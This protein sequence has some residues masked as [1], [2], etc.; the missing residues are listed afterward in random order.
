MDPDPWTWKVA[1]VQRF[2]QND[3]PRYVRDRGSHLPDIPK[4]VQALGD[5]E[6]DGASL[7]DAVDGATLRDQLGLRAIRDQGAI[8]YCIRKLRNTS[9]LYRGQETSEASGTTAA[10]PAPPLLPGITALPFAAAELGAELEQRE[11]IGEHVRDHETEVR[12]ERGRKRRKLDLTTTASLPT[13]VDSDPAAYLPDTALRLDGLFFGGTRLGHDITFKTHDLLA[14]SFDDNGRMS[15]FQLV[16]PATAH[17]GEVG[18]V[19]ARMFHFLQIGSEQHIKLHRRGKPVLAVLPYPA[20]LRERKVQS[21]L[22]VQAGS[23]VACT[24]TRENVNMLETDYVYEGGEQES[25]GEWDFLVQKYKQGSDDTEL[26]VLGQSEAA[27]EVTESDGSI[28]EDREAGEDEDERQIEKL[29]IREIVEDYISTYTKEWSE[30]KLPQWE[31]KRAWKVWRAFKQSGTLRDEKINYA[32]G[33]IEELTVRLDKKPD[34]LKNTIIS[35]EWTTRAAVERDCARLDVTLEDLIEQRWMIEV[36]QRKKE[37]NHVIHHR[38]SSNVD[39]LQMTAKS[40]S[41]NTT[42]ELE[43]SD[44]ISISPTRATHVDALAGELDR[45]TPMGDDDADEADDEFHTPEASLLTEQSQFPQ[46]DFDASDGF[47]AAS[48]EGAADV[49]DKE[50]GNTT[51]SLNPSLDSS[52]RRS[53]DRPVPEHVEAVQGDQASEDDLPSPSLLPSMKVKPE[54]AIP[55]KSRIGD[56]GGFSNHPIEVSSDSAHSP[57]PPRR[58]K[59]NSKSSYS[60]V[61]EDATADTAD[62]REYDGFKS[63]FDR[64]GMLMKVL[65]DSGSQVR[66]DLHARLMSDSRQI[67]HTELVAM[68][69]ACCEDNTNIDSSDLMMECANL[70]AIW[71]KCDHAYRFGRVKDRE[72]WREILQD[73]AQVPQF[74]HM[75]NTALIKMKSSMF[76]AQ[77]HTR[78]T[79]APTSDVVDLLSNSDG[80]KKVA[81]RHK[82][83]KKVEESQSAKKSRTTAHARQQR[84]NELIETQ[85][86]ESSQLADLAPPTSAKS[87]ITINP[88]AVE[89]GEQPIYVCPKIAKKM[90][91]HQINGVRFLWREITAEGDAD[92]PQGCLLAHTMG[93]GKTMQAIA[94]L[95]AVVEASES[96]TKSIRKQ[97]PRTLRLKIERGKRHLRILILCPPTLLQNWRKEIGM[98]ARHKIGH[99]YVIDATDKAVNVERIEEWYLSGGTLLIGFE[100][101]R[102]FVIRNTEK[103]Q[104]Q[105]GERLDELLVAGP[106]L[107]VAD[108]AHNLKNPKAN[109]SQAVSSFKTR[110]RV[111]LTGT[112]MSNDVDEIY[113]LISW[114]APDYL[115]EKAWFRATY[116]KPIEDGIYEDSTP[117]DKRKSLKKLQ[118]LHADIA[119]KVNRAD[120]TVLKGSLPPKVEFVITVELTETQKTLYERS[121][122]ALIGGDRNMQATQVRIFSW[123]GLLMLLTNHP[124]AFR[125]KLLQPKPPTKAKK[126]KKDPIEAVREC[127]PAASDACGALSPLG[128][129]T[130]TELLEAEVSQDPDEEDLFTLGFTQA[131]IDD[132]LRGIPDSPD[133]D[134]SAKMS[135]LI[136]ILNNSATCNDKVLIFSGSIP[137]IEYVCALLDS[138]GL[139]FGRIDG[140]VPPKKRT[141]VI[142]DF[143]ENKFDVMIVS[144]RAGGVGLNIQGANRVVILDFSFNPTWE[145]QAIGRAYRLG[146]IKPVFVYRFVAGGTFETNIYNKQLF[147]SSLAQRVVDKKNPRRSAKKNTR[148]YLYDPLPVGQED[149][150][151]L[152]GKDPLVLDEL[153]K[154]QMDGE[155]LH[156]RSIA[157]METLQAEAHDEPL[158]VEEQR[159]VEEELGLGRI[160]DRA[161]KQVSI[162]S[163]TVPSTTMLKGGSMLNGRAVPP[164]LPIYPSTA[165]LGTVPP[166]YFANTLTPRNSHQHPTPD[167]P[168]SSLPTR[169]EPSVP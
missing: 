76:K 159:E 21:A 132:I 102:G 164:G 146:Q 154:R 94:L 60:K 50:M 163:A 150:K 97:L 65:T 120:I 27:L 129:A 77:Q 45:D 34:G 81:P 144:T 41:T 92:G 33:R 104:A 84:Y 115:G 145:E 111:A 57:L 72:L 49:F 28:D 135:I 128:E 69:E 105:D 107:V 95:V 71:Y 39:S 117:S 136:T 147:K 36:W 55:S 101:Y 61:L 47:N 66:R 103:R 149:V 22:V 70:L 121:V 113:A 88:I 1:D 43:P 63:K 141:E 158:S 93:L 14:H 130:L 26:P 73:P 56:R 75:L 59:K 10:L 151:H 106:E 13:I 157:T 140:K 29:R 8:L 74:A 4:F 44:R 80:S 98:W 114:V 166:A 19:S 169:D 167:G 12:D 160:K 62:E 131:T 138:Q 6:V 53:L 15:E 42:F 109:L 161:R 139:A 99:V 123:L 5:N 37:P 90:M 24:T 96:G 7:L 17:A 162:L 32:R 91:A 118:V 142:N 64:M 108:E 119:P 20:A 30:K 125:L 156:I 85:A 3:A 155:D 52:A 112:P 126:S 2:F 35:E 152:I 87:H 48:L 31:I 11:A 110:S 133:P 153:L 25:N 9:L 143:H 68:V 168:T 58:T 79:A 89:E 51:P 134:L 46:D 18:F 82:R 16:R 40:T 100:M 148:D 116:G 165:P 67:F 86:L 23:G 83:K 124:E 137:T 122:K 38:R 78:L 127:S 54:L